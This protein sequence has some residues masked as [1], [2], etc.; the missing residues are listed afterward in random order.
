[1][2]CTL[3]FRFLDEGLGGEKGKKRKRDAAAEEAQLDS[4]DL[5]DE[6]NPSKIAAVPSDDPNKP[7]FGR[8]SYDGVIAGRVSGRKWKQ[9]RTRRASAKAVSLKPHNYEER[10]KEKE[11]KKAY[12]ERM[13][14]L[15]EEIRKNKVEKRRLREER[16]KKK[17]ENILRS[18]TQWQKITNPK[19]LK[20]IAKSKDKKKLKLVPDELLARGKKNKTMDVPGLV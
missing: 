20:K 7:S 5:D 9:V 16:E 10:A 4:M 1:M 17:K 6:S 14:E 15:K 2:A 3:D 12:K 18:G 13:N 8:P 11:I 19:T